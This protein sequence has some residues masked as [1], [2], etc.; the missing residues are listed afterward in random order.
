MPIDAFQQGANI[1][2]IFKIVNIDQ[3]CN[4]KTM[5]LNLSV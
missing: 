5:M 1:C 3:F 2:I 4:R